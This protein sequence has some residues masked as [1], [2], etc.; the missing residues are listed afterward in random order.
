MSAEAAKIVPVIEE[1]PVDPDAAWADAL[2]AA[3]LLAVDPVGLGGAL[4]R[5]RAG[6]QRAL[7][8]AALRHGL[9]AAV[10][11]RRVPL[12]IADERLLGGLDLAATLQAGRPVA[13][14]GVLA[15]A[16]G[17]LL[18][19]AMAERLAAGTAARLC[20]VLDR[21][22]VQLE[23]DGL[24][25]R[26]PARLGVVAL[27]EGIDDEHAPAAL[28]DRLAFHLSLD[29][30]P[31]RE[32]GQPADR[33]AATDRDDAAQAG[34]LASRLAAAP[35]SGLAWGLAITAADVADARV[36]LPS[37]ASGDD[38]AAA[39]CH[40]AL[41]LGVASLRAPWLALRA[42]CAAAALQGHDQ[43]QPEDAALA[44][45]LVLAPRAT[46]WPAPAQADE[47]A[48]A[49]PPAPPPE[50]SPPPP[51]EP[52]PIDHAPAPNESPDDVSDNDPPPAPDTAQPLDD[53][54]L[55]AALSALPAGLL[56][57]LKAG[58][59]NR[60][61]TPA[62]GKSGAL[63]AGGPRGRP[64]GARRGELRAGARLDLIATLRAAAP[65]Q[66]LRQRDALHHDAA[67]PV[68]RVL[69][70]P[71]DFHICRRAQRRE[72]TTL[73]SGA[74][75][76]N[77]AISGN[78]GRQAGPR[79]V[80]REGVSMVKKSARR[81]RRTHS[82]AFKAQ[83]ALAAVREDKTMTELCKEYEVHSSQILDWKRQLLEGAAD[84][85][86]AGSRVVPPVDLAP[87]HA[88]IGQL[89]LENDF[90]ERALTKAGLLSAK[91]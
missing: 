43:V 11:L 52:P 14:R 81:T 77:S 54:V 16:D 47:T 75:N 85:F 45:R 42:A 34:G 71:E 53:Q 39:L 63:Q 62:G 65:W 40:A 26:Q 84:V 2:T 70:R 49:E 6:P 31:P 27:D 89:A 72:T 7:W 35:A 38:P 51:P 82:P 37:V 25:L 79:K 33:S 64:L 57:R 28:A 60:A 24:A 83:V 61:P 22:E 88:K 12:H 44:A 66:R 3:A 9:P 68:R 41:A 32:P 86:G 8:L 91:P 20:A 10:P 19:L 55:E 5:A 87:L 36:R 59:L 48:P 56:A 23:R 73:R 1:S 46:R 78:S 74:A 15:E 17:G 69:V 30:L 13:Q 90:L 18:L 80:W 29:A 67:A 4:L 21:G 58:A 76:L 50:S